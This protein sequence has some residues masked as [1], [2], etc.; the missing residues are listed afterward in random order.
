[1]AETY[2]SMADLIAPYAA[3]DVGEAAF[4]NAVQGLIDYTYQ[5]AEEVETFLSNLEK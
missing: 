3:A 4:N 1:M 5:R 2:Q